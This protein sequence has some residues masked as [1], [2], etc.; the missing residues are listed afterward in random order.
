MDVGFDARQYAPLAEITGRSPHRELRR[1][2]L[3]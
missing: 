1:H 3:D 2:Q